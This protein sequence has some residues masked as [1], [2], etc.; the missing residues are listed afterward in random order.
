MINQTIAHYKITAKLGQG[1]MGEVYRATD[2]QLDRE[3]A[4][5][6]LPESFAGD[7]DRI[8]R[9]NREAKV[10][11][12]LNHPN[13]AAIYGIEKSEDVHALVMELVE[14]ETLGERLHREP[15]TV[16]E[17]LDCCRQIAEALEAAH[18]KGIIHRDLK[19]ENVKIDE[20]GRVKVLDFGLAK[21]V[22]DPGSSVNQDDSPTITHMTTVP[23]Q[24]LGTAPYMS[25]EQARARSV[26]KRSD[27]W[28]F[29]CVLYEC[30]AGKAMFQGEDVTVTLATIIKGEP[31][32]A[33]LPAHTPPTIELLLRKCLAKDRKRR[34]HDIADA[35]IDIEQALGDPSSSIFRLSDRALQ[36]ALART[37]LRWKW[38]LAIVAGVFLLT[39]HLT[40]FIKPS[41]P[42]PSP[43]PAVHSELV[44]P[45]QDLGFL[46]ISPDARQLAFQVS[47][48]ADPLDPIRLRHLDRDEI[49]QLEETEDNW[50][51]FFSPDGQSIGYPTTTEIRCIAL[52]G[53]SPVPVTD[54]STNRYMP[55]GAWSESGDIIFPNGWRAGLMKVPAVG[56]KTQALTQLKEGERSHSWPQSLPGGTH[57]L[58]MVSVNDPT[59][60]ETMYKVAIAD[61]ATGHHELLPL[62]DDCLYVR[63][64]E[65]GHLLYVNNGILFAIPFDLD[66][67]T[68]AGS[69]RDMIHGVKTSGAGFAYYD[70]S[71]N[72]T[73][74]Y[75]SGP[76]REENKKTILTWLHADGSEETAATVEGRISRFDLSPDDRYV[77][78]AV[79]DADDQQDIWV[80]D[81]ERSELPIRFTNNEA[82]D[83]WPFWSTDGEWIYFMSDR[84]D[85]RPGL[86]KKRADS[87]ESDAEFVYEHEGLYFWPGSLSEEGNHMTYAT[88]I[89]TW[90]LWTVDLDQDDPTKRLLKGTSAEEGWNAVSPDARWLAY[91]STTTGRSELYVAPFA[92]PDSKT[93]RITADGGREMKWSAS[94]DRLFFRGSTSGSDEHIWSVDVSATN[95]AIN[96]S[97]PQTFVTLPSGLRGWDVDAKGER[98][99]VSHDEK[100]DAVRPEGIESSHN[101]VHVISN[102]FTE[103]NEKCPPT[104]AK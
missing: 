75:K 89:E 83:T 99:L 21:E 39:A 5:K 95:D 65:S 36:Q 101:V 50:F 22:V 70:I 8:A 45:G 33:A 80:I 25:P 102:F 90:D 85:S 79:E 59:S 64:A 3:V 2:T 1:G 73:L 87:P 30:L 49:S 91:H 35:R 15:M 71:R 88:H 6:I 44:L 32:W 37:G 57:V 13:I 17:A 94:G 23:G 62:E 103:L 63:Y 86:W 69:R 60:N 14:G 82:D 100:K 52:D 46:A 10:L 41:P 104:G 54:L 98:I 76:P 26:D 29:G 84:R 47:G 9:F 38:V 92:D 77:A 24:L 56:G 19:P 97:V 28:S 78:M 53:S 61:L 11:A 34:L 31:D 55:G 68:L 7:R 4:I 27:I 66:S 96:T 74:V 40:W 12:A 42:A 72:G 93:R 43:A 58:F 48:T 20:D 16:T 81:L 51:M 18:E 67:L